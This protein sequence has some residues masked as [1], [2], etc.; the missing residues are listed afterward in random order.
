M[1]TANQ[2]KRNAFNYPNA[3][4]PIMVGFLV[5][6]SFAGAAVLSAQPIAEAK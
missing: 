2:K 4:L 6:F 3:L 5:F 1:P